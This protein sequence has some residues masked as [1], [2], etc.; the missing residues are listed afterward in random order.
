MARMHSRKKGKSGSKKPLKLSK[1]IW[2]RYT[3]KEVE[4]LVVK[5]SKEG[6]KSDEAGRVL[7]DTYGIPNVKVATGKSF[8]QILKE[9]KLTPE[10]PV[11]LIALIKRVVIIKKHLEKNKK[12]MPAK[13]GLQL[14][15][16][17]IKR[18]AKYYRRAEKLPADWRYKQEKISAFV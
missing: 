7:R 12:D 10:L 8:A 11:D 2:L 9:K 16:S 1:P 13:R 18:L 17:K 14:T 6:K 3:A 15:E 4:L 5:L